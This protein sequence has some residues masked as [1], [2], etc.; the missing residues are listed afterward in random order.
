V[1]L[2]PRVRG[3]VCVHHE[4]FWVKCFKCNEYGHR[5]YECPN[6]LHGDHANQ[7]VQVEYEESVGSSL[8]MKMLFLKPSKEIKEHI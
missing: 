5:S 6:F 2:D 3:G 4:S 7:I 1:D 8:L